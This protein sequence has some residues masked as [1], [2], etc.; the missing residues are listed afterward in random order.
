MKAAVYIE[1]GNVEKSKFDRRSMSRSIRDVNE[2][3]W[4]YSTRHGSVTL[5]LRTARPTR[6]TLSEAEPNSLVMIISRVR[7]IG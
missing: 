1:L 3:T 6:Q 7:V 5:Q 2:V 4:S